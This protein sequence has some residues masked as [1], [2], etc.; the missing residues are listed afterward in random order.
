M[1]KA[2]ITKFLK[3]NVKA[4]PVNQE[5]IERYINLLD[6]YYQLDKAIKKDGVTVTTENGAQ[7]FTKVHPAISEKNKINASLLNIE[8]SFGFDESPTVILERREL[9]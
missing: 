1:N 9:L 8:K 5:K 7:K 3:E 2:K 6:I 4:T